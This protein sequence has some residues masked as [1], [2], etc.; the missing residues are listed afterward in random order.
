MVEISDKNLRIAKLRS[1]GKTLKEIARIEYPAATESSGTTIVSRELKKPHVAK[2]IDK[3]REYELK[4]HNITWERLIRKLEAKL[5]AT[6]T[7]YHTGKI[8]DDNAT[9]LQAIKMLVTMLS[10][11]KATQIQ[12][13]TTNTT[14]LVNAIK[15]NLNDVEL[16]RVIFTSKEG[17]T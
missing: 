1:E 5:E 3:G 7:D 14:E 10:E 11:N 13:S 8:L 15:D 12:G 2:Y 4:K 9:Q 17:E 16:Q 6:K